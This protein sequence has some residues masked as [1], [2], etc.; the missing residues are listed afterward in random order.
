[1][2]DLLAHTTMC[3]SGFNPNQT[4]IGDTM[5]PMTIKKATSIVGSGLG[6]PSKMPGT[7]FGISAHKCNVGQKLAKV[8]GSVCHGCYAM[9]AN[10]SY[11]SVTLSH[12][13]RIANLY[14]PEWVHAM[15]RLID[16]SKTLWHRWHDSGDLQSKQHLLNIVSVAEALPLVGFW[17]PTKEKGLVHWFLDTFGAFPDNLIV[18]VSG[19]MVDDK[20]PAGFAHTSTV[21]TKPGQAKHGLECLAYTRKGKCGDCRLCWDK[22]IPSVSYPKH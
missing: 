18:R 7:S 19:A 10:Y 15:V 2:I 3:A 9:G 22:S 16:H 20:P 17:L 11:P 5:K 6:K 21:H 14:H 4:S 12:E 13:R 1:M 8:K